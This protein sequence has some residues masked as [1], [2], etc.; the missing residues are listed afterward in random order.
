MRAVLRAILRM[1]LKRAVVVEPRS[2]KLRYSRRNAIGCRVLMAGHKEFRE[3]PASDG[4]GFA[5]QVS[6]GL[7]H[8]RTS[9]LVHAA[10]LR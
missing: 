9:G 6:P 3:A 2:W 8:M 7:A 1:P 5:F 10:D 4:G